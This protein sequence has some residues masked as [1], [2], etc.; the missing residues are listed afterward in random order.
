MRCF[1][2]SRRQIRLDIIQG[3]R[4]KEN[5]E[6]KNNAGDERKKS[7][8]ILPLAYVVIPFSFSLLFT[9]PKRLERSSIHTLFV[10]TVGQD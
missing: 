6:L 9:Q 8:F 5:Y 3:S 10:R 2:L 1:V 4:G 7:L